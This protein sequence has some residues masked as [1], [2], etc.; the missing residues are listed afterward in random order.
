MQ[1]IFALFVS[2]TFVAGGT[3]AISFTGWNNVKSG[4]LAMNFKHCLAI[5]MGI[6]SVFMF[7]IAGLIE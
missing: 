4:I 2:L 5:L 1:S 3:Y 6:G 7:N